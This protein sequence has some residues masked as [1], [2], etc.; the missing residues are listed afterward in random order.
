MSSWQTST[1]DK[2]VKAFGYDGNEWHPMKLFMAMVKTANGEPFQKKTY[3]EVLSRN[4]TDKE[5][6]TMTQGPNDISVSFLCFLE[7]F[8]AYVD[9]RKIRPSSTERYC[10]HVGCFFHYSI[11]NTYIFTI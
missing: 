3:D 2:F 4:Y 6:S 8:L 9:N 10:N 5:K 1:Y 7:E 11:I